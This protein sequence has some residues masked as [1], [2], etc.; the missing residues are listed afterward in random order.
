MSLPN[1]KT[2]EIDATD[3]REARADF[4]VLAEILA[5]DVKLSWWRS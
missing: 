3:I 4:R 2:L 5:R 1:A